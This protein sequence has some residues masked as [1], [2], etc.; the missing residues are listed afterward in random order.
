[1][2]HIPVLFQEV[3][4]IFLNSHPRKYV[5]DA[6]QW[7]GWHTQMLLEN[8]DSDG[9]CV[10]IDRD[11]A[12]IALANEK[13]KNFKNHISVNSSF[14]DLDNILSQNK[15][16]KIDFIL[17]DLGVSSAHYD[18]GDRGFSIRFDWPLDMRFNRQNGKTARDVVMNSTEDELR[19]IFYTFWEEKKSPFIARAIVEARKNYEIDTTFKLLEIIEK[20]SFDKKSPIRVFQALRIAVND[21]FSHII[22]SLE[23]AI[24]NLSIWWKIAVITFHSLEDRIV[25]QFF[26]PYLIGEID[27]LTGQT[28]KSAKLKKFV[29]KPI[30]PT[31]AE[32]ASNPRSRSAKLRVYECIS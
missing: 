31:E 14:S 12:N 20:S 23:Q 32:I 29:K 24:N 28:T 25:K 4:N 13:L 18:D 22:D 5:I 3:K 1:M 10:G 7:L 30:I 11:I 16:P 21:E 27:D 6:T 8:I 26:V 17:Y 2:E 19:K 9:I 15:I